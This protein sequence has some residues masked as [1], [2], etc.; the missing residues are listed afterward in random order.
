MAFGSVLMISTAIPIGVAVFCFCRCNRPAGTSHNLVDHKIVN[1]TYEGINRPEVK[2]GY[3]NRAGLE[4]LSKPAQSAFYIVVLPLNRCFPV[5]T[6]RDDGDR[7]SKVIICFSSKKRFYSGLSG[8]NSQRF[9]STV[10]FV[11]QI[12]RKVWWLICGVLFFTIENS[13]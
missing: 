12:S 5:G 2:T 7:N 11:N 10:C 8:L 6:E 9:C 1:R 3:Q 13:L 4:P